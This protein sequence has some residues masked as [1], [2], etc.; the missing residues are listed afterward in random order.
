MHFPAVPTSVL[1]NATACILVGSASTGFGPECPPKIT[2]PANYVK[3]PRKTPKLM[4]QFVTFLRPR[5]VC[6][7][8]FAPACVTEGEDR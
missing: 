4:D 8:R 1:V 3:K 6:R 2:N 5:L 7:G